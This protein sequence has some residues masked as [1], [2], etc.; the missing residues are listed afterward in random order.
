MIWREPAT[1]WEP[2]DARRVLGAEAESASEAV[3]LASHAP[4][5]ITKLTAPGSTD[6]RPVDEEA[7]LAATLEQG[8][9]IVA[10]LGASGSGK[11]HMVR[12]L[13]HRMRREP[14]K[15]LV[16][17][18]VPKLAMSLRGIAERVLAHGEGPEFD[19]LRNSVASA[20]EGLTEENVVLRL[21]SALANRIQLDGAE[22]RQGD[23]D[24]AQELRAILSKGLPAVLNDPYA[25]DHLMRE[26]APIRRLARENLQGRQHID[27]DKE[28]PFAFEAEDLRI[29][30]ADV[31]QA[32]KATQRILGQLSA[33]GDLRTLG[34]RMLNEQLE[35]AVQ[36]VFSIGGPTI[37][38]IFLRLRRQL[39]TRGQRLL[40]LIE[41]FS[42][43]Q[44]VERGIIDALTLIP[45]EGEDFCEL[46]AVMAVTTGY[47][48]N[49]LPDTVKTRTHLAFDLTPSEGV[50]PDVERFAAG[51]LNAARVGPDA[52]VVHDAGSTPNA[53]DAC[54]VREECHAAF[55]ASEG[56]GLFPLSSAL[57]RATAEAMLGGFVARE[58]LTRVLEPVLVRDHADV[59]RGAF[60]GEAFVTQHRE[61]NAG[62]ITAD[63]RFEAR[64][65]GDPA[66]DDRRA[67]IAQL[68]AD[69]KQGPDL[70]PPDRIYGAFGVTPPGP[71]PAPR[72]GDPPPP[73]PGDPR[74]AD[75]DVALRDA[76]EVWGTTG[77]IADQFRRAAL[78]IVIDVVRPRLL[79]DNGHGGEPLWDGAPPPLTIESFRLQTDAEA[80]AA[81]NVVIERSDE[82]VRAL[83][84]LIRF[85]RDG[86][87][88]SSGG[89]TRR[90]VEVEIAR[91]VED[92]Q[93]V[94]VRP[95]GLE[96]ELPHLV[97]ALRADAWG[98]GSRP[99]F[100]DDPVDVLAALVTEEPP[101]ATAADSEDL[102]SLMAG[103]KSA[104]RSDLVAQLL[105][106]VGH[107]QGI[108]K[109]RVVDAVSLLDALEAAPD[110]P[111][112]LK[113]PGKL[114]PEFATLVAALLGPKRL[115]ARLA[116][117]RSR[118][119]DLEGVGQDA[120]ALVA[121]LDTTLSQLS[122]RG[123]LPAAAVPL[124]DLGQRLPDLPDRIA[125]LREL[126]GH[127]GSLD[128]SDPKTV[129]GALATVDL[130][131][132]QLVAG[133]ITDCERAL[134]AID[135]VLITGPATSPLTPARDELTTALD[136]LKAASAAARSKV[137][138]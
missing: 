118:L 128:S 32:A 85:R 106:S 66:N 61:I 69:P 108:G 38:D 20:S 53:C 35:G 92:S 23:G 115:G 88:G 109:A 116:E 100:S 102:R 120:A 31:K 97:S 16:V 80:N 36:E 1:C 52:L 79:L 34:A 63:V 50:A 28:R 12:W 72:I 112:P 43:F 47:F 137:Q 136:R 45:G 111:D 4:L 125:R 138:R 81:S 64:V 27:G 75:P 10:I 57:V 123:M 41:D 84:A 51:Y 59:L 76:I 25:G 130:V 39:H 22:P 95:R 3:F 40:L 87:W 37:A 55:G 91:W 56:M 71:L 90:Y 89:P 74:K 62:V 98:R 2:D 101:E 67:S 86:G 132:A 46:R 117:L 129:L 134:V 21:R 15:D 6:G 127:I 33:N 65:E 99:A 14:R 78:Q 82:T 93:R 107:S 114:L 73:P 24:T 49:T 9:P 17:V 30:V 133:W 7:V 5:P 26:G 54:P 110:L 48:A 104:K 122:A 19:E 96:D 18:F 8:L 42:I 131:D 70:W 83:V 113:L 11:S 121:D 13:R 60:P 103:R 58:Y 135:G 126:G 77:G 94:V 68:Y 44:G 105:R 119:P 124:R 29:S